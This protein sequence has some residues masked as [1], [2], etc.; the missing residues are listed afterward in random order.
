MNKKVKAVLLILSFV[1]I[2]VYSV[3]SGKK[4]VFAKSSDFVI[5]DGMLTQYLGS[6]KEI[7]IPKGVIIIGPSAFKGSMMEKVVIP[8]NLFRIDSKA[9]EDCTNLREVIIN[10][11]VGYIEFDVFKNCTSLEM[12]DLPESIVS[13]GGGCFENCTSLETILFPTQ[14]TFIGYKAFYNTPWLDNYDG[15]YVV[16][17]DTLIL[18][19]GDETDIK[20]PDNIGV[21]GYGAFEYC[22][23]ITNINVPK[24]VREIGISAFEGCNGLTE[25][26]LPDSIKNVDTYAFKDCGNL[27]KITMPKNVYMGHG[28]FEGTKWLNDYKGDFIILNDILLEYR[29]TDSKITIPSKVSSICQRAFNNNYYIKEI[30]IPESVKYLDYATFFYC[31]NLKEVIFIN[32]NTVIVPETFINCSDDLRFYIFS[33]GLVEEYATKNNIPFTKCGLN[34]TKVTLYI[35][36]ANTTSLKAGNI[37]GRTE[38]KSENPAV[39]SIDKNGKVT[40]KKIGKTKIYANIDDF[41]F[42]CEITVKKPYISKSSFSITVGSR[43]RLNIVGTS[44]NITWSTRNKSIATVNSSGVVTANKKGRTI[45]TAKVN[46]K[47]YTCK[48]TVK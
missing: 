32:G 34:K 10:D 41:T 7:V 21:I 31:L 47:K 23:F 39:A 3:M 2:I 17:N 45:I 9:F 16:I 12:I 35:G 30:T 29:G 8:S 20:I 13:I 46:G 25:I 26:V 48:V 11:G 14:L 44:S 5:E 18:Y 22:S 1:V 19:R 28:S 24:G 42:T 6:D 38:W 43:S 36:G 4:E 40:A 27:A 33:G 37:E 15:D